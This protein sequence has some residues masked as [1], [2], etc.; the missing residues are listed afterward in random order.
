MNDFRTFLITIL[1]T[2]SG[3]ASDWPHYGKDAGGARHSPLTDITPA[4]VSRLRMAWMYRTGDIVDERG[5]RSSFQ[6]TPL[7]IDGTLY[8]VTPLNRIIALDAERGTPRWKFDPKIDRKADYGD[9]LTCR[10]LASW[11]DPRGGSLSLFVATQ[12]GRLI[13]VNGKSGHAVWEVSL[14]AKIEQKYPGEYHF[15]SPPAVVRD[16]VV[17]GSAINDNNRTQM[18]SGVVRG[19]DART[20]VQ[21]WAW[22]PIPKNQH[23]PA[24]ASWEKDSALKTGAG[25]AWSLLS[26]DNERD[27]VFIPTGSP[28]PDFFGGERLGDN[29]YANS[30]VALRGATGELVWHFQTVHHDL[31]DY[32]VPAQ[33]ILF[34]LR[35]AG[36]SVP[37]L[38]QA[39]K[40][41]HLFLLNRE[42]GEPLFPVEE[43]AVPQTDVPGE[44]TSP[45]QPFPT[46]PPPLV[47][48]TPVKPEDAWGI[49]YW[50]SKKCR[51]TIASARS[52]GIFTPPSL[53]GSIM[54]P[55]NIGG[56]NWGSFSYDPGRGIAVINQTRLPFYVRLYR[57]E[58]LDLARK[59]NPDS[60]FARMLGTPYIMVRRPLFSMFKLPCTAPPWGELLGVELATGKVLWREPLGTIRD[61]IRLPLMIRWGTPNL[62]GP[63]TTAS[64]LAF[65][66]ATMDRYLRAFD[67]ATGKEIWKGRLPVTA[68]AT[69]LTYRARPDGKQFVVIAA[70]GHAKMP[71]KLG[72]YVIAYTLP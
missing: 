55:G 28:S 56:S 17:V 72:D 69:P 33:P 31:W 16:T 10:G 1:M 41:G 14:T 71:G 44:R 18:P 38:A 13:A 43:R 9:G 49:A 42:T 19:F 39:T 23:D 21:R 8:V 67:T 15:T 3:F 37:S 45:T 40:M 6:A 51:E 65:I 34:S 36:A 46:V 54:I 22:D 66:A 64:G 53:G 68:N 32:D 52:E 61:L 35:T 63:M 20:G 60:E 4:N 48:S 29:R 59:E 12:D 25:N 47:T 2:A 58:D 7:M 70:G 30:V 50:D 5:I 62:G 27:L 57:R 24:Y 11:K 26:A